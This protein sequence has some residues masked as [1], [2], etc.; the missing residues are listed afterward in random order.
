MAFTFNLSA[1]TNTNNYL[2]AYNIYDNVTI[3]STE[4]KS[5]TSANGKDWKS[6]NITFGNDEGT[7]NHSIFFINLKNKEDIERRKYDMPNGGQREL[8]SNAETAMHTMAAIAH[9]FMPEYVD[10]LNEVISKCGNNFDKIAEA[11]KLMLD[12]VIDKNTTSM[13]L[14]G[15]N[16][17]GVVYATLPNCA[18]CSEIKDQK[19]LE[20]LNKTVGEGE[21]KYKMG[22]WYTWMTSP[23][24]KN[25]TFSAYELKQKNEMN[26]AKPTTMPDVPSMDDS[27]DSGDDL[28]D[29][30]D[31]L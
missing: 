19:T 23:F 9:A 7:Y 16:R 29:L 17:D 27:S 10:K 5:G 13:K 24:G 18:V 1:P 22:D 31:S 28:A 6:L 21:P 12:K 2:R 8:P 4:I 14:V 26:N 11:Y 25:L 3:K 30:L 20:R 15:R